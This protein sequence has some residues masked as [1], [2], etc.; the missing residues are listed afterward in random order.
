M[1]KK[2]AEGQSN[3][4]LQAGRDGQTEEILQEL[5]QAI[6]KEEEEQKATQKAGPEVAR[7]GH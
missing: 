3:L 6:H 7:R 5:L 2:S 1:Q 4:A